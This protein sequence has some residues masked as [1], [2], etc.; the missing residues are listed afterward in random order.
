[1]ILGYHYHVPVLKKNSQIFVPSYIGVFLNA[2]ADQVGELRLFLHEEP[3][4]NAIGYDYQIK[5]SNITFCSMGI[6]SPAWDRLLFPSKYLK[7]IEEQVLNCDVFLIRA[8][9]PLAPS[10][11]EYFMNKTHIALLLVG[12]YA[13]GVKHLVQPWY[14]LIAISYLLKRNDRQLREVLSKVKVFVNSLALRDKYISINPQIDLI[15][16]SSLTLNDFYLRENTCLGDEVKLLYTGRLDLAKGLKELIQAASILNQKKMDTSVHFVAWEDNPQK[17]VEQTLKEFA[18]QNGM[19]EKVFFHGKKAVG[20]D[21]NSMYRMAD[22]YVIPSY[23][24]GFPRTIWE[25]M[26]NSLP[27]VAT[28]VGGIPHL[29]SHGKELLFAEVAN[30][31]DLSQKIEEMINK[32][33]LRVKLIQNARERAKESALEVQVEKLIQNMSKHFNIEQSQA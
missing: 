33:E 17:P 18:I 3:N 6:K 31:I 24:E 10:L 20:K 7:K 29:L 4:S 1:M 8:P 9:S 25:A 12:D 28:P 5:K 22:I 2:L 19:E 13:D 23:H 26:A 30:S 11:C 27:V 21:L 14:R 15:T 16:T 32:P